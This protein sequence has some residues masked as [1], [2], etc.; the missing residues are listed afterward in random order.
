LGRPVRVRPHRRVV[1]ATHAL[2]AGAPRGE[3]ILAA[4]Y[5]KARKN[6]LMLDAILGDDQYVFLSAEGI[7]STKGDVYFYDAEDLIRRK[8][9]LVRVYD[10][11]GT[12]EWGEFGEQWYKVYDAPPDN[13]SQAEVL[14]MIAKDEE[15]SI[16]FR[17]L[18][19]TRDQLTLSGQEAIDYLHQREVP[20]PMGPNTSELLVPKRLAFSEAKGVYLVD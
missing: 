16:A 8:G 6:F 20:W 17:R 18:Q 10:I 3:Y 4:R 7:Y 1:Y 13:Y 5:R 2:T 12:E 15:L 19:K 14:R 11:A 9:A